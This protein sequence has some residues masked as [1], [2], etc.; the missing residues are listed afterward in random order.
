I[1]HR[2]ES[3]LAGIE[4]IPMMDVELIPVAAP[5]FLPASADG[6]IPPDH[7]HRSTQCVIRDSARA[8]QGGDYFLLD[9]V[10]RCSVPDHA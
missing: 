2:A 5:G 7:L 3:E 10:N 9:G 6:N 4:R 8:A 1:F